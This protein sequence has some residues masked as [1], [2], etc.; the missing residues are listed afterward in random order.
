MSK[1]PRSNLQNLWQTTASPLAS[2]ALVGLLVAMLTIIAT[3]ADGDVVPSFAP[4]LVRGGAVSQIFVQPDGKI[5]LAGEFTTVNGVLRPYLARL[6]ADGTIDPSFVPPPLGRINGILLQPD[7]KILIRGTP[8]RLNSDGSRDTSF[9]PAKINYA[10]VL[11]NGKI[12]VNDSSSGYMTGVSRLSANGV[13]EIDDS[14]ASMGNVVYID[15]AAA[16]AD[17]KLIFAGNFFNYRGA[18]RPGLAR[19]NADWSLDDVFPAG[20]AV[21]TMYN[22]SVRFTQLAP[23]ADGRIYVTGGFVSYDGATRPGLARLKADGALDPSFDPPTPNGQVNR[24]LPLADGGLLIAGTFT[25]IGGTPRAQIARL[26]PDGSLDTTF[27]PAADFNGVIGSIALQADGKIVVG[28]DFTEFGNLPRLGIAR[29]NPDGSPDTSFVAG[30]ASAESVRVKFIRRA[31]DGKFV[32][33]GDFNQVSGVRRPGLA[34]LNADG[35][36]DAGFT[37]AGGAD[38]NLTAVEPLPD[39]KLIVAS[40]TN[41]ARLVYRLN[42]DGSTDEAFKNVSFSGAVNAL[43]V[44]A[45]GRLLIGGARYISSSDP[46]RLMVARLNADGSPDPTFTFNSQDDGIVTAVSPL[47]GGKVLVGGRFKTVGGVARLNL[48]RLNSNGTPDSSFDLA[49]DDTGVPDIQF[50]PYPGGKVLVTGGFSTLAGMVRRRMA[51]LNSDGTLDA[52]FVPSLG[53]LPVAI[54]VLADGRILLSEGPQVMRLNT[55]GSPDFAFSFPV[56]SGVG[57]AK[58]TISSLLALPDGKAITGGAFYQAG[59]ARTVRPLLAMF[60]AGGPMVRLPAMGVASAANY[61]PA[62][63]GGSIISLFG[64]GLASATVVAKTN[65]LPTELNGVRVKF[66]PTFSAYNDD[67]LLPLFF[68]SEKQINCWLQYLFPDEGYLLVENNGAVVASA[69]IKAARTAPGIFTADASGKGYPA[70]Q[71]LRVR[72]NGSQV[73]EPV[74]TRNAAGQLVGRPIDLGPEGEQVFLVLYAT[75]ATW[76]GIQTTSAA[77]IGEVAAEIQYL[78]QAPGLF[79]VDQINLRIPRSLKGVGKD[80]DVKLTVDGIAANTVKIYIQ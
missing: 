64:T 70:A 66:V 30:T 12:A 71:V 9:Q 55:D 7:G 20:S 22:F 2:T 73:Y 28:G 8:I 79:G 78:G 42:P 37:P 50:T 44:Q 6:N 57:D 74:V 1:I 38:P 35:S 17:G 62:V 36:L 5:L 76:G 15:Q 31:A 48:A 54:S 63:A 45:D 72:A 80:V 26:K 13:L 23:L 49:A 29:L 33:A 32:I 43:V 34:R 16:Q 75:G 58:G 27:N 40:T 68:V 18:Q 24:I 19:L 21:P 59:I 77:T 25:A 67:L 14:A 65:P 51:L 56:W 52:A 60:E 47:A 11:P 69:T 53:L 3:A 41:S 61:R 4:Q 39:G 46:P 10:A